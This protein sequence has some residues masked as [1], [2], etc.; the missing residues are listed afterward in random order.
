[1]EHLTKIKYAFHM[2]QAAF[3]GRRIPLMVGFSVT[4]QCNYRCTYCALWKLNRPEL[5]VESISDIFHWIA[6]CHGRRVQITGGEPM[7][8][9]DLQQIIAAAKSVNLHV[10]L[11]TNGYLIDSRMDELA[12][13]DG[14]TLSLDGPREVHDA[15]KAEGAHETVMNAANALKERKIPF[16]FKAVLSKMNLDCIDY[17]LDMAGRYNTVV[18][19]QP[20]TLHILGLDEKNPLAPDPEKY[21]AAIGTLINRKDRKSPI[22]NS[23]AGLRHLMQWPS[24]T[25]MTP[26]IGGRI[27]FRVETDG[28]LIAC[29]RSG[30]GEKRIYCQE[31][32]FDRAFLALAQN[33]C[34]HCWSAPT[35]EA[36]LMMRA[37]PSA[38]INARRIL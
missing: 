22:G 19:F 32:G 29:Q 13:L 1:M 10:S 15:I 33:P 27:L 4:D 31:G 18:W 23:R 36:A 30:H 7:M 25:R 5:S 12:G 16:K 17:L 20:A 28:E 26:C 21:K 37:N 8:R 2:A 11:S 38:L 9:S 35:V 34:E 14:V 24:P 3:L 6:H